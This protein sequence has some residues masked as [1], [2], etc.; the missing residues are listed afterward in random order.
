LLPKDSPE[1]DESLA[2]EPRLKE[3]EIDEAK[4]L[5]EVPDEDAE[6]SEYGAGVTAGAWGCGGSFDA[7][8]WRPPAM[9]ACPSCTHFCST[10]TV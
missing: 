8:N 4:E 2:L 9:A 10:A 3:P 6:E 1:P 5:S 7:M